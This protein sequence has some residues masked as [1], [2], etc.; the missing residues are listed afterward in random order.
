MRTVLIDADPLVISCGIVNEFEQEWDD[1]VWTLSCNVRQVKADVMDAAERIKKD[2]KAD[3]MILFISQGR[4]FRHDLSPAYKAGRGRKP[5]GTNEVKR[6]LVE[7]MGAKLKPGIEADDA[8]GIMATHPTLIKGEKIV[9]SVDKDLKTIPGKLY[10]DGVVTDITPEDAEKFF[11]MQTLMGDP[12]DG[13][14]GCPGVGPV[15]AELALSELLAV[16][17]YEHTFKSGPRK[18][19]SETR[20]RDIPAR[21]RWHVV[22]SHFEAAGLTEDDALLQ[23]RLARILHYTDYDFKKK[24]PILWTPTIAA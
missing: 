7:E 17:P 1:D 10:R 21:D 16:E 3:E 14:P 19:T 4:T 8:L 5:V 6:W 13:Y 9:A 15:R 20:Y 18:G 11:L 2:L 24:E 23:A 12:T 22:T